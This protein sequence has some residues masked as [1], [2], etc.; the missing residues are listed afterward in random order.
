VTQPAHRVHGLA[1]DE[2]APD[3]PPLALEELG[4]VFAHYPDL[5]APLAIRWRSPRPLAAAALVEA[6]AGTVFAK[7]HHAHVRSVATLSEEHAF[8]AHLRARG[9]PV[10]PLHAADDGHTAV[11]LG[12][13]TWELQAPAEGFDLY[14]DAPSWTPLRDLAHARAAG[15]M[16]ARLHAAAQGFEAAQRSTHLLVARSEL[17]EA[18][19]PVAALST[20]LLQ[21]P[22]LA[23]WLDGRPWEAELR[24]A[25]AP[26]HARVQARA[27]AQPR[28]WTHGDWHASNLFWDDADSPA[29]VSA[30]LDFGLCARTFALFDLATAV[31]RNAIAWLAPGE[32]RAHSDI[33]RALIAGY[34]EVHALETDD[35]ALLADLL[36]VIHLDFALSEVEYY[37]GITRS[38]ANAEAAWSD[39]LIG[40][41]RWFSSPSGRTLLES[42]RT[43]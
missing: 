24:E 38:E 5:A 7:R 18:S 37:A 4:P 41:A 21:R 16:L 34:R 33:A 23:R 20:Q 28:L 9:V 35:M 36:P 42:I 40:H 3:W 17:I 32:F 31:E 6:A 29:T 27:A 25:L 26:F 30:V 2:A 43:I 10:P 14:R 15:A 11:A 1:G 12:D 39:F 13:W 19:D 22:A 8:A